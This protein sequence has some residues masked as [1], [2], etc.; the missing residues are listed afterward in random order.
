MS[1]KYD[2]AACNR[3]VRDLKRRD[4]RS[5]TIRAGFIGKDRRSGRRLMNFSPLWAPRRFRCS[6]TRSGKAGE[7]F[8]RFGRGGF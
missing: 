1:V 8:I 7:S 2:N 3:F 6:G 4:S 5:S